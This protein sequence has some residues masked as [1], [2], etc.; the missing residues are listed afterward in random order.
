MVAD[1]RTGQLGGFDD[2]ELAALLVDIGDLSGTGYTD[3]D[4][5]DLHALAEEAIESVLDAVGGSESQPEGLVK[6]NNVEDSAEMYADKSTRMVVL[7]MPIP[8]FIWTQTQLEKFRADTGAESNTEAIL[9]LLSEWSGENPPAA[10]A[11]IE[12]IPGTDEPA[13]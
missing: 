4:L 8:Q 6:G 2:G 9:T 12:P 11:P 13:P 3:D 7:I 10:D 5:A 1:N